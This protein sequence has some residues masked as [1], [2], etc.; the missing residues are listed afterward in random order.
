MAKFVGGGTS[1]LLLDA[2]VLAGGAGKRFGGD[3]LLASYAGAPL[4]AWAIA[5]A[6]AAPVRRAVLVTGYGG[7]QIAKAVDVSDA[8]LSV[9]FAP[10]HVEGM[11]ATLRT[12]VAALDGSADGA[13]IFLGD[14]P[15]IPRQT[16]HALAKALTSHAAAAPFHRGRRGHPVLFARRMLPTLADLTGDR[17]ASDIIDGLDSDLAKVEVD[18]DGVLFD[19]DHQTDLVR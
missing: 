13:F 8:R 6:L 15:R 1:E 14:M 2:V 18:D 9:I 19:V 5:A 16:P 11:A 10:D 3:K 12:G 17:G 4:I 7:D